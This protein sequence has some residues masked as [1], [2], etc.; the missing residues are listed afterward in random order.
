MGVFSDINNRYL[1]FN[2]V[3]MTFQVNGSNVVDNS[4]NWT[5]SSSIPPGT[6]MLFAQTTAPT[7]WTKSLTYSDHAI[8]VVSGSVSSGGTTGFSSVSI[9]TSA[10]GSL[11]QTVATNA[12]NATATGTVSVSNG[13][14]QSTTDT[15]SINVTAN[16]S[17]AN[18]ATTGGTITITDQGGTSSA[19]TS[20]T[21]NNISGLHRH[22]FNMYPA[23]S[24]AT[25]WGTYPD[26]T[27]G[28]GTRVAQKTGSTTTGSSGDGAAHSH[29]TTGTFSATF[30][31]TAHNHTYTNPSISYNTNSH[32]HTITAPSA[33]FTATPHTHEQYTHANTFSGVSLPLNVS[34]VDMIV[35]TKA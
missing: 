13:S 11:S 33:S 22:H 34:Y 32:N 9:D 8:R 21:A 27:Q 25:G 2:G 16:G 30:T 15:G 19:G 26:L 20:L 17:V 28:F 4:K 18:N 23:S 7:G 31:E 1:F 24:E 35:A 3:V 29:S 12:N 6:T 5:G 14:A 10:G